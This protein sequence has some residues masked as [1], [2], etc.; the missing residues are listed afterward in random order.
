M[1]EWVLLLMAWMDFVVSYI[2]KDISCCVDDIL[3]GDQGMGLFQSMEAGSWSIDTGTACLKLPDSVIVEEIWMW[4]A[5]D[6]S[7]TQRGHDMMFIKAF[8]ILS[9]IFNKVGYSAI[10]EESTMK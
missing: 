6:L 2:N 10:Q 3:P 9:L 8:Y 4:R 5:M 1:E 7:E